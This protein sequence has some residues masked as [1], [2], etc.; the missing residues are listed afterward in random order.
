MVLTLQTWNE[1]GSIHYLP[2]NF[3][4]IFPFQSQRKSATCGRGSLVM[5]AIETKKGRMRNRN[6]LRR[7]RKAVFRSA[8]Q[9]CQRCTRLERA[10]YACAMLAMS[11]DETETNGLRWAIGCCGPLRLHF[12]WC[13]GQAK[14]GRP[15]PKT[16]RKLIL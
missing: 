8:V 3:N 14:R 13:K 7:P 5:S 16:H 6:A 12:A 9:H 10:L 4:L 2:L 15:F 11:F 1:Q